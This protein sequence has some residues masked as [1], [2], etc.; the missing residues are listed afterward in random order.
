LQ[1]LLRLY[2]FES[3]Q[4]TIGGLDVASLSVAAGRRLCT[5]L[6]QD[7]FMFSGT[8]RQNLLGPDE[9]QSER[10]PAGALSVDVAT[11]SERTAALLAPDARTSAAGAGSINA[12][13][14]TAG[15]KARHAAEVA[16]VASV[17]DEVLWQALGQVSMREKVAGLPEGLDAPVSEGGGNW[18]AGERALLCL[19]RAL[20]RKR[21]YGANFVVA[22]EPTAAVDHLADQ[23]VH[24]TLLALPD[25]V[26]CIC[27]RLHFVPRF[28]LVAV[29]EGGQVA[30]LGAPAD[31]MRTPGSRYLALTRAAEASGSIWRAAPLT[32]GAT[33]S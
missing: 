19:A 28:D 25:T 18:S 33:T 15:S 12:F 30:E 6:L 32:T 17:G 4:L 22:D 31:L 14:A 29:V 9:A 21:L 13:P 7:G 3:G 23:I 11:D 27:H 2:P 10:V 26:I 5:A 1:A 8:V 20:L 24:N 16:P